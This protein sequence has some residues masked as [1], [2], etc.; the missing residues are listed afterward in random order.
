MKPKKV[1]MVQPSLQPPGGGNAVCA[2]I[3]EALKN[4]YD[5]TVL[6][7]HPVDLAP[8]NRHYGT[9][10]RESELTCCLAFAKIIRI[11]DRIIPT[12]TSLVKNSLLLRACKKTRDDYDVL[13]TANNE[14]DFGRRGI[15]YIH[16]PWAFPRPLVDLRWY[17]KPMGLVRLY[18]RFCERLA[19]FSIPHMKGNVTLVNSDW[20]GGL[21]K[22][23]Y[24]GIAIRTVYPPVG[25]HFPEVPWER[26]E[27]GFLCIG[28][29]SPEKEIVKII[30]ILDRVRR[31]VPD[32]HLHIVGN[33]DN[34]PYFERIFELARARSSWIH[35]DLDLPRASL[36][37]LISRHQFGIHGME[38]EHFGMAI[39]EMITAGSL[40]FAPDSGGPKE[41]LGPCPEL[42]Y[43]DPDDA[44][45]KIV[46]VLRSPERQN[47]LR[48]HLRTR[49]ER[50]GCDRFMTEIRQITAELAS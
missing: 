5:L 32:F 19:D 2:W 23:R 7:L 31:Q 26:K 46:E 10:L 15:Q 34:P 44:V 20:I 25:G 30:E 28:R 16:Y 41:I 3:L 40:V 22:A 43:R 36:L 14:A 6:S 17:H 49:A 48:A 50:F 35:L 9:A 45:A 8:I 37:D 21:V 13:I 27:R 12:P 24:P 38:E 42:L 29:I 18:H 4:D 11:L 47:V 39:A 33:P 1:L